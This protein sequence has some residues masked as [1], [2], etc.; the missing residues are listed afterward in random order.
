MKI[1]GRDFFVIGLNQSGKPRMMTLSRRHPCPTPIPIPTHI[2]I[3]LNNTQFIL[4]TATENMTLF[5]NCSKSGLSRKRINTSHTISCAA[6]GKPGNA[7][8]FLRDNKTSLAECGERVEAPAPK[9]ALDEFKSGRLNLS[10]ALMR[11]F[12]VQYLAYDGFCDQCLRSGG[13]CGTNRTFPR[14]FACNCPDGPFGKALARRSST[15]APIERKSSSLEFTTAAACEPSIAIE[16]ASALTYLHASDIIHRDVKTNNILLDE[17][18]SVNFGISRFFPKLVTHV[19]TAPQGTPGYVDPEY[20]ECYQLT[21][22]SDVFSFGVVLIELISSKP[23]VDITRHRHE[24]NLSNMAINKIQNR[25]LHELVDPTL[26]YESD[27]KVKTMI[28][29]VAEVAF[30]CLQGG[31]DLR[32]QW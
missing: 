32:P 19:S 3:P 12:N 13:R 21:E 20:H 31:K 17:N 7:V 9:E 24:I 27:H 10:G 23:A 22:K 1:N 16:T 29:A 15:T 5:S 11:P 25:A 28:T 30:Q 14:L 4:L 2:P 8:F 6:D 26:G 18:F